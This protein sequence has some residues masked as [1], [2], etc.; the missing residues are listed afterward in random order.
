MPI[1]AVLDT[2]DG[3]DD[4]I[5]GLYVQD[6]DKFHLDLDDESLRGHKGVIPLANAYTATKADKDAAKKAADDLKA[7]I[8]ELKKGAPDTAATQAKLAEMQEQLDAERAKAGEL[9]GKYQAVTRDRAIADALSAKGVE[10]PSFRKAAMAMIAGQVKVDDSGN[11]FVETD[12][13]AR[14]LDQFLTG[15]L[16]K[17]G[18]DFVSAPTGGGARG[19]DAKG[20]GKT[21]TRAE[22]ETMTP[23]QKAKYFAEN[24]GVT[25]V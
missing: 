25:V 18:A 19:G 8:A 23:Q 4:A 16:A 2:L 9:A 21:I 24:K 20:G 6:G 10:K 13:G 7:Q 15:W 22:L 11:A 12:L 3:V 17:E 1:A 14:T 5:K